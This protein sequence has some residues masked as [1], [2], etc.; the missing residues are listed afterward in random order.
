MSAQL[1]DG[2]AVAAR[3]KSEVAA[4]VAALKARGVAPG[5]A[6]IIVG[7]NAASISY[8]SGKAADCAEVG[9]FSETF[10]LPE[11]ATHEEVIRLI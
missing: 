2:N 10:R 5:L 11:S 4:R 1:I 6:A 7:D 8:V 9:I 3:I